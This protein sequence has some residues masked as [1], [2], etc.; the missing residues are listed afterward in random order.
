MGRRK[1]APERGHRALPHGAARRADRAPIPASGALAAIE[2]VPAQQ[3][4]FM[5]H[6][7]QWSSEYRFSMFGQLNPGHGARPALRAV[8]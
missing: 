8:I 1:D 7:L 2:L 4:T 6:I 3:G 5:A